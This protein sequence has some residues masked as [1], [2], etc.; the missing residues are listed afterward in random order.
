MSTMYGCHCIGKTE[1]EIGDMGLV[2]DDHWM[3][4]VEEM[5]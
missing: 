5:R 3:V 2:T 4:E 1:A